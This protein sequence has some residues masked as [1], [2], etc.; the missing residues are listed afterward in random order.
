MNRSFTATTRCFYCSNPI[1]PEGRHI[2]ADI[3]HHYKH[4]GNRDSDRNFHE[5]CF[6]AFRR[7]GRP[8]NPH[9]TYEVLDFQT[10]RP[11]ERSERR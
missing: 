8:I 2:Y 6:Q 9:T 5:P 7:E 10:I 3:R 1:N 4:G 11:G